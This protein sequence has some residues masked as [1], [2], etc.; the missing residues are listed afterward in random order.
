MRKSKLFYVAKLLLFFFACVSVHS[1]VAEEKVALQLV[2]DTLKEQHKVQFNYESNLL[3]VVFVVPPS[4][5]LSL[6]LKEFDSL[7]F[8]IFDSLTVVSFAIIFFF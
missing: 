1:Q 2:I 3:A 4:E 8:L 7:K 5:K 6:K